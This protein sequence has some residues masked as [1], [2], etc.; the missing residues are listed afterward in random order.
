MEMIPQAAPM[1]RIARYRTQVDAAVARVLDG[2]TAIGGAEVAKFEA[3]FAAFCGV[4]HAIG[5]GN[6]TDALILALRAAGIGPGDEVVT[7]ALTAHGTAQAIR[8]IGAIPVF[9]EVDALT[10]TMDPAAAAAAITSRTAAMIPVHLYGQMASMPALAALAAQ[11][12]LFLLEDCAQAHGAEMAGRKAGSWGHAAAFSFYPTKNLGAVGDGGA[13]VT[14]DAS[15][16]E[17]IR[18]QSNYGWTDARRISDVVAGNSRLDTIQAAIL[19]ALLPYLADAIAERRAI[20]AALHAGIGEAAVLPH[21]DDGAV[22]HQFV[23][24]HPARDV[25]AASLAR[26]GIGTAVHYTP[27]L[28]RQP[29]F[30]RGGQLPLPVTER[31]AAEVLSLPIQPEVAGPAIQSIVDAVR[32]GAAE[33]AL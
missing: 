23:I 16:A 10:R 15:L 18:S 33:C 21:W 9:V 30:H 20:A 7:V 26:D 12:G 11:H 6:G 28:H 13:V 2:G 22:W 8:L 3:A 19:S 31:L 27:P 25:L 4:G 1:L 29:A 24:C 14:Q 5:C 32:K 17:R